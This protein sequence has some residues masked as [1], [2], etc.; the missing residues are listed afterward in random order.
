MS[1]KKELYRFNF[2]AE[3]GYGYHQA[4]K[5]GNIIYI[6]GQTSNDEQ[7]QPVGEGDMVAQMRQV[8]RNVERVLTNFGANLDNIVDEVLFVT[9]MNAAVAARKSIKDEIFGEDPNPKFASTIVEIKRL[10][11]PKWMIE[12]KFVAHI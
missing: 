7:G 5:V 8:Y 12:V 9:D 4:V 6:A 3:K 1:L 11:N 2:P 10:A